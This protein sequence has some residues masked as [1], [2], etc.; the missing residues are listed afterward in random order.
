MKTNNMKFWEAMKSMQEGKKVT[1]TVWGWEN[2][3]IYLG[4]NNVIMNEKDEPI[5][6]FNYI[7]NK[8]DWKIYE[9]KKEDN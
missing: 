5:E 1:R 7:G 8:D 4:K 3:Y 2:K 9:S 6:N